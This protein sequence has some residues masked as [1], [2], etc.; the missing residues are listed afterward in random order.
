MNKVQALHQFWN[1]YG[2]PAYE[3]TSVPEFA[4]M[5]YITY[6]QATDSFENLVLLDANVWYRSNS[7]I[8]ITEKV[9]EIAKDIKE[10]GFKI[11]TFHDGYIYLTPGTP[12]SQAIDEE[13]DDKVKRIYLNVNA[14]YLCKY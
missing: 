5:P 1:S 2:I 11:L 12:F 14:E 13:S 7:W 10:F 4:T 6:K 8:E 9:E 3:E